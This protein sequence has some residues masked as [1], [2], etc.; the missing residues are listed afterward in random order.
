MVS[1]YHRAAAEAITR[2]G[3]HVAKYLGDGVMAFSAGVRLTTMTQN[4]RDGL[5]WRLSMQCRSSAAV[6][7]GGLDC[8]RA[9]VSIQVR[10]WL[11]WTRVRK[12]TSSA[13]RRISRGAWR[14]QPN[15]G[16]ADHRRDLAT[17]DRRSRFWGR[18]SAH[19]NRTEQGSGSRG[20]LCWVIRLRSITG[21][22][23]RLH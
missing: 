9:C 5:A 21:A 14:R 11:A 2:F 10:S 18:D 1:E 20:L 17:T 3:G 6:G 15:P 19:S 7:R 22:L 8:R 23:K 4:A 12:P 16:S 13:M